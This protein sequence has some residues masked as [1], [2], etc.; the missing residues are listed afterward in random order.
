[1]RGCINSLL[2]IILLGA[3]AFI[4]IFYLLNQ[5][6]ALAAGVTPV[7]VSAGAAQN[8]DRKVATV[9]AATTSATVEINEQEA[10]SKLVEVL[11]TEPNVPDIDNPQVNFRDGRLYV[12]GTTRDTLIPVRIVV[13]GRV[14]ARDGE[15]VATVD[16]IDTGRVPLPNAIRD[17]IAAAATNL[18]ELNRQLPIYVTEVRVLDGRLVLTGYPK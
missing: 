16:Q 2:I 5:R 3:A 8:F 1:M 6:P 7:V 14:E 4:G 10:T 9:R 11:A 18:D 15:I 13:I 17:E 12:S